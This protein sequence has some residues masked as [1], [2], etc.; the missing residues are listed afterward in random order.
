MAMTNAQIIFMESCRL[1][2]A[3]KIGTTGRALKVVD[4]DGSEKIIMEPEAIHTFAAWKAM[5]YKVRKGEHAIARFMIWKHAT[6]LVTDDD[7]TEVEKGRMF[8]KEAC[9]FAPS[10]VEPIKAAG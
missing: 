9:F 3:G 10:Q 4:G 7:G 5:G 2:E 8:L 6:K 1:M